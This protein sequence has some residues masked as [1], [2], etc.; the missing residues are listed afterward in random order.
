MSEKITVIEETLI[1]IPSCDQ[2][3]IKN[4]YMS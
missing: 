4:A 3:Q 1:S 2:L